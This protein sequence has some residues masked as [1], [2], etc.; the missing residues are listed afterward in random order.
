MQLSAAARAYAELKTRL[1]EAYNLAEDDEAIEGTADGELDFKEMILS[2]IRYARRKEEYAKA[3]GEIIADNRRRQQ[4]HERAAESVR[5]AIAQ[6]MD[7]AGLGKVESADLTISFRQAKPAPAIVDESKLP[8]WAVTIKRVASK[9]AINERY[10]TNPDEEIP[11]VAIT[12]GECG[13]VVRS[14]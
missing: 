2:S 7:D 10:K 11:G 13:I 12:N 8:D 6:A 4:R 5:S 9:S 14:K 3:I 1:A